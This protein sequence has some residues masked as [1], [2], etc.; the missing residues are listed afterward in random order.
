MAKIVIQGNP[1]GEGILTI[2]APNTATDRTITLPDSTGTILD[3]TSSLPAANL[4]G[5]INSARYTDTVA[6]KASVEALG[7][8]ASS[9]TGAL[10]A[11]SGANLTGIE[12]VTKSATVPSSPSEGDQWFNTSAS[13]VS[14]VES[15][16][17]AVYDGTEWSVMTNSPV[18]SAT[19][20]AVT[21]VGGYKIHTFTSSGTFTTTGLTSLVDVLVVAGG[22]GG[23]SNSGY[24]GAWDGGGGAGGLIFTQDHSVVIGSFTISIGSGGGVGANGGNSSALTY[25]AIGG[26]YGGGSG[27]F[28]ANS[29]GSGGGGRGDLVNLGGSGTSGQGYGGANGT[30]PGGA[31]GWEQGGGGG[32]AGEGG[33]TDGVGFGGDGLDMSS[34][35]G[36]TYGESGWFAGGGAGG[37]GT[38]NGNTTNEGGVGG[39]GATR[40][41][42]QQTIYPNS[43]QA[44]TGGGG[45][46]LSTGGSGIVIIRYAV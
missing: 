29:G 34:Y 40:G 44:N 22:G 7:I 19:G 38:D 10:P 12:T 30:D 24:N 14:D 23:G 31:P 33:D 25:T 16:N 39:G 20:G 3:T 26:G 45:S 15:K 41:G 27:S 9:I 35:F 42:Y 1:S 2:Q 18:F 8:A 4:T 46:G 5:T 43:G 13:T 21:T 11:I 17:M 37:S 32:G 28:A 36:T 6:T